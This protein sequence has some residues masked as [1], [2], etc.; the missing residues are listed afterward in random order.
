MNQLAALLWDVDGTLAE[1]ERDGHRVA[2][3]QAFA[4][5]GLS[6]RWD[7]VDYGD[8]LAVAGGRRRLLRYMAQ[9]PDAP[10]LPDERQALATRVHTLKNRHY[11]ELVR[12]G[13][14]TLRPGVRELVDAARSAGV[15]LA[16]TTT[17]SRVNLEV[18]LQTQ[19][20]PRWRGIFE[21][22][23]CAAEA[24]ADKPDP[25]IYQRALALL[26]LPALSC[27]AIED[28]TG[29]AAAARAADV[30]VLVTRSH[31][32]AHAT[33]DGAIAIGPGLHTRQ[34][35]TPALRPD[36]SGRGVDLDDLRHWHAAMDLVS[37]F[38]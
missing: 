7:E 17:T 12:A 37:Q 21:V 36:G 29:G 30:P 14:I 35:W 10:A 28:S 38:D 19:F 23:V 4:D 6:W 33:I 5:C 8:L 32:F 16:V 22:T 24:G 20:G 1:T 11:G 15:R 27:L 31:Y 18:L 3:N 34:G 13:V 25:A 9:R 26:Q 2:F